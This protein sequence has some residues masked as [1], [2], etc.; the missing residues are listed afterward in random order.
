MVLGAVN[1]MGPTMPDV[2]DDLRKIMLA[3]DVPAD[4]LAAV[5]RA[6]AEIERLRAALRQVIVDCEDAGNLSYAARTAREA[7]GEDTR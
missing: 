5:V 4:V 2:L 7:I 1:L 3:E 6:G